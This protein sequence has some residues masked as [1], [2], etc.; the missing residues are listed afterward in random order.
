MLHTLDNNLVRMEQHD[1]SVI[2]PISTF[3]SWRVPRKPMLR[4]RQPQP[5]SFLAISI[6]WTWQV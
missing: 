6:S 3:T 4:S 1:C 2:V 5:S